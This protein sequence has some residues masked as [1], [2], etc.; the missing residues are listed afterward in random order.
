[1][2][3]LARL[4]VKNDL[5]VLADEAY[6]DTLYQGKPLSIASLPGMAERTVILF[7]FSK[8]FAMT[9]WRLGA[10]IGPIHFI[11]HISKINVN[12]DPAPTISSSTPPWLA[13]GV[14]AQGRN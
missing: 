4:S 8:K 5:C 9:G 2:E 10:A 11:E 12:D 1:M 6:F 7:T 3:E 14:E 13:S